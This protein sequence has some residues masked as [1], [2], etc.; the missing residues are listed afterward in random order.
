MIQFPVQSLNIH[1]TNEENL[2]RYVSI[3]SV[4]FILIH[5]ERNIIL[6]QAGKFLWAMIRLH[7][8]MISMIRCGKT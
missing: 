1:T 7:P 5:N 3:F 2:N 4:S 6:I 8:K